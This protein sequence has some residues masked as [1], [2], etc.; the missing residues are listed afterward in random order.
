MVFSDTQKQKLLRL[1]VLSKTSE[2]IYVTSFKVNGVYHDYASLAGYVIPYRVFSVLM[3][4]GV[5]YNFRQHPTKWEVMERE[6]L[7][8]W[9]ALDLEPPSKEN[10]VFLLNHIRKKFKQLKEDTSIVEIKNFIL[11]VE[12]RFREARTIA[13]REE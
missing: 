2:D 6:L 9:E 3:L 1:C 12:E 10:Y 8:I 5:F 7:G 11:T 4:K 13:E